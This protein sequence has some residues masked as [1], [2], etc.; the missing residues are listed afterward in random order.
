[1]SQIPTG[2]VVSQ[3]PSDTD[4]KVHE[5]ME[6]ASHDEVMVEGLSFD[7]KVDHIKRHGRRRKRKS[8]IVQEVPCKQPKMEDHDSK[9]TLEG[10]ND[11]NETVVI[12]EENTTVRSDGLPLI[13]VILHQRGLWTAAGS[14]VTLFGNCYYSNKF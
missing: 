6:I 7:T 13:T 1:M 3:P 9:Q 14:M 8:V 4:D 2:G 5:E 11:N 12:E 10:S